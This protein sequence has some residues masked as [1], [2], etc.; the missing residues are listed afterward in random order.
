MR[1][2][3]GFLLLFLSFVPASAQDTWAARPYAGPELPPEIVPEA[4]AP[5]Q[6]GL[7]DGLVTANPSGQDIAEAWYSLP[8]TRYPHGVLGDRIEAGMLKALT[9]R[10][11]ILSLRLP[12]TEVFEDIAPRLADLDGNGTTEIITIRSSLD[13][14]AS[15]T[16]YGLE[17]GILV[18]K[19]STGF[20]GTA[21]RWLNIAAIDRFTGSRG[22]EI[23]FVKTPHIGGTLFLYKY[24][25]GLLIQI[26]ALRGFSNHVIGSRELRLSAVADADGDGKPDLALPSDD[27]RA[28]RIVGFGA[29]G[30]AEIARVSLS[31]PIDKA[32]ATA[33][34][35]R[36]PVFIAGLE[37][38]DVMEIGR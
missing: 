32:I 10:G 12:A 33:S 19:A 25:G 26:G 29:R 5:A 7:P 28:L 13:R 4:R 20:I 31:S 27:R 34:G 30:F 36:G 24:A 14:G 15:L 35:P 11:R 18:E 21:N 2:A 17:N 9:P 38:G 3:F 23:A 37:N 1:I 16:I 22:S 8:T 6:D